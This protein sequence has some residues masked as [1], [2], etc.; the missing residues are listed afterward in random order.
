MGKERALSFF[1]LPFLLFFLQ[2]VGPSRAPQVG[3]SGSYKHKAEV[4][5]SSSRALPVT[6]LCQ[7]LNAGSASLG[8]YHSLVPDQIVRNSYYK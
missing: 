1:F 4:S 6:S 8:W 2:S 3:I 7:W 5:L